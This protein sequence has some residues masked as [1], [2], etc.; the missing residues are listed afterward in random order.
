L[1]ETH[2]CYIVRLVQEEPSFR[3]GWLGDG[4]LTFLTTL[5]ADSI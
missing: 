3:V 5:W 4:V 1:S 2:P